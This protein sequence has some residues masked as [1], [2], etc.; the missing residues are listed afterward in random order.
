MP[1][2]WT[3]LFY[4][5]V[6]STKNREPQISPDLEKRLYPFIGGVVRDLRASLVAINGTAD[7][8]HLLVH[9]RADSAIADLVRHV[10]SR[11]SKWVHEEF[12]ACGAFGWQEGYG[13]FT[14]SRSRVDD[15]ERYIAAQKTHHQRVDFKTEFLA[16][17]RKHGLETDEAAIFS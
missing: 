5:I 12:P 1:G 17:L 4:H 9:G 7:H 3:Q 10:K 8:A 11:S 2:A 14:V 16:L 6:F 15:V 13:A